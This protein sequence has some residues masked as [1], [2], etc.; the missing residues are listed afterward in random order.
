MLSFISSHNK[1]NYT[2]IYNS[3]TSIQLFLINSS[4]SELNVLIKVALNTVL[5]FLIF[6]P[7][8][9]P[10][11]QGAK[12]HR[13]DWRDVT[14]IDISAASAAFLKL[15]KKNGLCDFATKPKHTELQYL[16]GNDIILFHYGI[17]LI[18]YH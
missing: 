4:F 7:S 5:L 16:A 13:T 12:R 2:Q 8:N 17:I 15:C 3:I 6:W 11:Q 9:R 14:S 1:H 10:Q 18:Y